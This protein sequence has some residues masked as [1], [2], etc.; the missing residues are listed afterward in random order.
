MFTAKSLICFSLILAFA[1]ALQDG[2]EIA[3]KTHGNFRNSQYQDLNAGTVDGSIGVAANTDDVP[4]ADRALGGVVGGLLGSGG[5]G[6]IGGLLG[7]LNV[8][9][10]VQSLLPLQP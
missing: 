6:P 4:A 7:G 1:L 5:T 2:D 10:P 3:P 9:P 8:V